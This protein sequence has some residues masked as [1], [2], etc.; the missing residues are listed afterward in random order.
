MVC[1]RR[2]VIEALRAGRPVH[3]LWVAWG[4]GTRQEGIAGLLELARQRHVPVEEVSRERLDELAG[5]H[6]QGVAAWV[7]PRPYLTLEQLLD[8]VSAT[9]AGQ[10]TK[11]NLPQTRE[12]LDVSWPPL[13]LAL[14]EVQ[15]PRNLG[16]LL[17]TAEAAGVDA[18]LIPE[19]RS[20]GLTGA[21]A[22]T[23]AGAQEWLPVARVGSLTYALDQLKQ[24]GLWVVGTAEEASQV[25]YDTDLSGPLVLVIG[26]EGSGLRQTV[27]ARCDT[28]V[29]VPMLGHVESL[30]ASVAG[31]VFLYEV[32]RQRLNR[33][34]LHRQSG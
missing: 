18:V 21:V 13:V 27:A 28:V 25:V 12:R 4:I 17:R 1:G 20:V 9:L 11:G 2:P 29:R 34:N 10:R 19:H 26:S 32:V 33:R 5:D 30:N 24:A 23:A 16:A 7:T 14:D 3:K 15:D 8:Q 22:K 31:G 6:H